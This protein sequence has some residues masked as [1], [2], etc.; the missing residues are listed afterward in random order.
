MVRRK[1]IGRLQDGYRKK[2]DGYRKKQEQKSEWQ[3]ETN[4]K[5][6]MAFSQSGL[7]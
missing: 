2:Q 1:V 4:Q 6:N 3:H 5:G 7:E